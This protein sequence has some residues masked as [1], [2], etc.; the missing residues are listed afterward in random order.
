MG[1]IEPFDLGPA[2]SR[3]R[4]SPSTPC[5][6]ARVPVYPPLCS[7][8]S[9]SG[10]SCSPVPKCGDRDRPTVFDRITT[11]NQQHEGKRALHRRRAGR[12]PSRVPDWRR[13]NAA[14]REPRRIDA[15]GPPSCAPRAEPSATI[16]SNALGK[17]YSGV[18][19]VV[20]GAAVARIVGDPA[21]PGL[22]ATEFQPPCRKRC[23]A[24]AR[25]SLPSLKR[26]SET[27]RRARSPGA[28]SENS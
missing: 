14:A 7:L 3:N 12:G 27:T 9:S 26:S 1:R 8:P 2:N 20:T 24:A 4:R 13:L 6:S 23:A 19:L 17:R 28:R 21:R 22:D 18:R 11:V 16:S 25:V 5:V 15:Q 10:A